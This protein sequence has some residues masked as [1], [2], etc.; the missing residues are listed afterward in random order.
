MHDLYINFFNVPS[1]L[2]LYGKANIDRIAFH[3]VVQVQETL[4]K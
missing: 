3:F 4:L 2:A 1:E